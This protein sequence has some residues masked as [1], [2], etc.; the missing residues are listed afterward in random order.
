MG[1]RG[2]M[3]A[4]WY[5]YRTTNEDGTTKFQFLTQEHGAYKCKT[6]GSKFPAALGKVSSLT[7]PEVYDLLVKTESGDAQKEAN[8]E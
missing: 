2:L 3:D 7:L 5:F 4:V 8:S 6:R 1:L